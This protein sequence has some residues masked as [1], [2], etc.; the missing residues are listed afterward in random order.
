MPATFALQVRCFRQTEPKHCEVPL[1]PLQVALRTSLAAQLPDRQYQPEGQVS[2]VW[3]ASAGRGGR[4]HTP[5]TQVPER[6]S[7]AA[8]QASLVK[9]V[10]TQVVVPAESALIS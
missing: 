1:E 3:Q 9:R 10:A 6:Q 7:V 2:S 4:T 5:S 8:G